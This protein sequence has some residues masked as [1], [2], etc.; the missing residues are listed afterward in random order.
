MFFRITAWAI[1]RSNVIVRQLYSYAVTKSGDQRHLLL[2]SRTSIQVNV[3]QLLKSHTFQTLRRETAKMDK[4]I[5]TFERLPKSIVPIHYEI[6][7]KPDLV[8]LV[9]EGSENITLKVS[10]LFINI[11]IL[12]KIFV[13]S[14]TDIKTFFTFQPLNQVV[15]PVNKI[16]LNSLELELSNVSVIVENGE[17]IAISDV[18]I[19]TENE[20]AIFSLP[21]FLQPGQVHLKLSFKGAII[22][23]LKGFYCSKYVT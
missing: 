14:C 20:S 7:I 1:L 22:D 17:E 12:Q 4:P 21:L 23:K 3:C 19:D 16:R 18:T 6:S 2:T 8:K 13:N 10:P 15:E 9:F 5:K 11:I